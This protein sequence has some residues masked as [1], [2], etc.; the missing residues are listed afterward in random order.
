MKDLDPHCGMGGGL[1]LAKKLVLFLSVF[2]KVVKV[3]LVNQ[4]A[5]NLAV[6]VL[7]PIEHIRLYPHC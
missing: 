5:L 2:L 1:L 6:L 3:T 7:L 4:S